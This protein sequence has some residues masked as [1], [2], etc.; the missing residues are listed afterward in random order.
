M[1]WYIQYTSKTIEV[2]RLWH[3]RTKIMGHRRLASSNY[4]DTENIIYMKSESM[5][6]YLIL[7]TFMRTPAPCSWC[8]WAGVQIGNERWFLCSGSRIFHV[9]LVSIFALVLFAALTAVEVKRRHWA[10]RGWSSEALKGSWWSL[11]KGWTS[12]CRCREARCRGWRGGRP[13][14]SAPRREGGN[15]LPGFL[16]SVVYLGIC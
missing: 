7:L 3:D 5:K 10:G 8:W 13:R 6:I 1:F 9:G 14:W 4:I 2:R 12:R 15:L 11:A 16:T